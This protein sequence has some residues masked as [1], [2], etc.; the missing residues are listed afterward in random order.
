MFLLSSMVSTAALVSGCSNQMSFPV[1][2]S[3][4]RDLAE[5]NVEVI[6]ITSENIQHYTDATWLRLNGLGNNPPTDPNVYSYR[7][8]SGDQLRIVTWT[9][10][11]RSAGSDISNITE[12]PVVNEAGEF[13]Y[14]FVGMMRARGLTVSEIRQNLETALREFIADPQVEV[15]VQEY[16]AHQVTITGAVTSPG[17]TTLTNVP[18]R[19]LDLANSTGITERSDLRHIIIR[20]QGREYMVNLLAF[21]EQGLPNHNP[22][23]LPADIIFVPAMADNRVF[24][25]GEIGVGEIRLGPERKTL[26]E[27]LAARGGPSRLR[28]DARG[29]FVFRAIPGQGNAFIVFQFNLLDATA[30][31]L[32]SQFAMAPMDVVFVTTD[33]ITRW[34]DTVGRILTPV[35]G[36]VRTRT[37]VEDLVE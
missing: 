11:E 8:G 14:P 1:N 2:A 13:F 15:A 26:T 27:V 10:P 35:S 34:N 31:M 32:T 19:L 20:R 37:I 16:R 33:P 22:I 6:P 30:L 3:A 9:T 36:V 18:L 7:I 12:G 23:L 28:A 24:T 4:S 17:S 29:I 25:F 21:M 5:R